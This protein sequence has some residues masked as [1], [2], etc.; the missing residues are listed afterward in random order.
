MFIS[1]HSHG[2]ID[3]N[4]GK[5]VQDYFPSIEP[6]MS[7]IG[8]ER[9]WGR[10]TMQTYEHA[11][12]M[13]GALYVG[14]PEYVAKKIQLLIDELGIQRFALHVPMGYMDHDKVLKT[15]ELFATQVRPLL[16]V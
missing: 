7:K 5:A 16:N 14:D 6:A 1:I 15:I 8:R 11:I 13:R 10:Y 4:H 2:Y 12:S 9:G 3:E